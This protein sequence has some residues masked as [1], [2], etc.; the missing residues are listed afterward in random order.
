[1]LTHPEY[2][3][4]EGFFGMDLDH[5]E[6]REE[7]GIDPLRVEQ[8]RLLIRLRA[9]RLEVQASGLADLL[10]PVSKRVQEPGQLS[11]AL[12]VGPVATAHPE[13]PPDPKHVATIE[14]AR[15]LDPHHRSS[16]CKSLFDRGQFASSRGRARSAHDREFRHHHR[17][18][19]DEHAIGLVRVGSKALDPASQH[20]EGLEVGR[21]LCPGPIEVDRSAIEVCELAIGDSGADLS[22]KCF[23]LV[24]DCSI[25]IM[26]IDF[27]LIG[28]AAVVSGGTRGIGRATAQ[29]FAEAGA[30]VTVTGRDPERLAETVASLPGSGH[31]SL[32]ADT[33]DL[34]AVRSMAAERAARGPVHILVN[35]TGGPPAG[36][37]SAAE[38]EA[39]TE[40]FAMHLAASQLMV[41]AF[42]P[43]MKDA[44][45]GRIINIISTSVVTPIPGLGVSNT[46]RGAVANWGR[47]LAVELGAFAITVNNLLPGFTG[48]DRLSTLFE[49][50]AKKLGCSPEEVRE[51]AI[52][53]IPAG[54]IAD[55][56]ELASVA[57]FLASPAGSYVNGVN[58]PVDGG[59]VAKG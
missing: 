23:H 51:Q 22:G 58:L 41:Q 1:M 52:R 25:R 6:P 55:P 30:A 36:P 8:H 37:A 14:G 48:T 47:T 11:R 24:V 18:V 32:L 20:L 44:G 17:G 26:S 28:R 29:A 10:H 2:V 27:S 13:A 59:R 15:G 4:G 43:G 5:I 45:Y 7:S 46:I 12:S 40:A 53:S 31:E 38:P 35:N 54:R 34:D 49:G 39:F 16:C 9:P 57:L 56:E 42:L 50:K 33:T 19:L 21:M 3:A